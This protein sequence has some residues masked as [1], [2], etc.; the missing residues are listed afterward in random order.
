MFDLHVN[1]SFSLFLNK[2]CDPHRLKRLSSIRKEAKKLDDH[3]AGNDYEVEKEKGC[4]IYSIGSEG[5]FQFEAG[6]HE[7][8]GEEDAC[9]IHTFD[10]GNYASKAP[11]NMNI[12][13]HQWGLKASDDKSP[14]SDEYLSLAEIVKELGHENRTIDVFK[15]DCENCEWST[16]KDWFGPDVPMIQ[17]ILVETHGVPIVLDRTPLS[18]FNYILDAGYVMFHK[19]PNIQFAKGSCIEFGFLKLHDDFFV[20]VDIMRDNEKLE[21]EVE[22]E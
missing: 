13:Y 22:V 12:H 9:E 18:F 6:M 21:E 20:D 4:L 5:D 16:V 14:K 17:Q 11:K 1:S 2:V 8:L 10:F 15:I 7:V 3:T 19:E